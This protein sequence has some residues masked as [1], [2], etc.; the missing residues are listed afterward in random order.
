MKVDTVEDIF[1]GIIIVVKQSSNITAI[2]NVVNP[3]VTL[4]TGCTNESL[5]PHDPFFDY[6]YDKL[7][8]C[9]NP[10][11]EISADFKKNSGPNSINYRYSL[12]TCKLSKNCINLSFTILFKL[13]KP[14]R[15]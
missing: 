3:G 1:G 7:I 15:K 14:Q 4:E 11:N 9:K 8:V 5:L 12:S 2:I 6:N 10:G 13:R